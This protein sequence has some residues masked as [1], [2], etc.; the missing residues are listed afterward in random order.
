MNKQIDLLC[1]YYGGSHSYGLN[2][3][4][5]DIDYRGVYALSDVSEIINSRS[6][7]TKSFDA[8]TVVKDG[9]EKPDVVYYEFRHFLHL[10]E[11]G[12]T[13]SME[14]LFNKKWERISPIFEEV[15]SY[16]YKLINPERF[17]VSVEGYARSEFN[18]A[19]GNRTGKLGG[20]RQAQIMK[21]GF[22]PKNWCNLLRLLYCGESFFETGNYPVDL[23][24][25]FIHPQL[26]EIKTHPERFTKDRLVAMFDEKFASMVKSWEKFKPAICKK[27]KYS[28][29]VVTQLILNCYLDKLNK[30]GQSKLRYYFSKLI[31]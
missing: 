5:S 7:D 6:H 4:D 11:K 1:R 17:R 26:M 20:K 14:M 25:S 28:D 8:L 30:A 24:G 29:E 10:L 31:P 18:L 19:I 12:S 15:Q 27:Y 13:T 22:S 3:P 23:T 9:P 2:T 21:F 16:K